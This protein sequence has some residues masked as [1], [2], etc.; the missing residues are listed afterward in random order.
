MNKII[1]TIVCL[2]SLFLISNLA[3]A[4]KPEWVEKPDRFEAE[5]FVK[6][7][8]NE[9]LEA[10]SVLNKSE[11]LVEQ[12]EKDLLEAGSALKKAKNLAEQKEKE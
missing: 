11:K 7:K 12:M 8:E 1:L 9:L 6:Q 2:S 5:N 4:D 10:E 3:V